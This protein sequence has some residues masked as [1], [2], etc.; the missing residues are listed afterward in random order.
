M[1]KLMIFLLPV[2]VTFGCSRDSLNDENV[3]LKKAKV[4][5]SMKGVVCMTE[6]EGVERMPVF[7]PGTEVPVP[8]VDLSREAWLSGHAT[9]TGN[10]M[11]QS[12]MTGIVAY[13]D[14]DAY[15]QGR[16]VLNA[17]YFGKIYGANG[18]YF[19][20]VSS[21]VIE[22]I[23]LPD[24]DSQKIITGTFTITGGSGNFE[25]AAG[26]GVLN[27]IVPCWDIDGTLNYPR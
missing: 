20:F 16:K 15:A 27:G 9:H 3:T 12:E 4:P 21:I 13:L 17:D 8:G 5:I 22:V 14:M 1:K 19:S 25:N 2:I 26:C 6:K 10:F 23:E 18:D 11:E 7:L 24:G